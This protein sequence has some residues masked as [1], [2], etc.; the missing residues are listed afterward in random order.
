[1]MKNKMASW[2]I[3]GLITVS[4]LGVTFGINSIGNTAQ[5]AEAGTEASMMMQSGAMSPDMM[6]SPDMQKQC[7]EMMASPEMQ[8]TMKDMMKQPQMLTMMKQMMAND[9]EFKQMMSDLVNNAT[10]EIKVDGTQA[11]STNQMPATMDHN[12]HHAAQ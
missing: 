8:Q 5:K 1:M 2:M 7:G 6:N 3:G 12:A 9:P 10:D 4:V 11:S